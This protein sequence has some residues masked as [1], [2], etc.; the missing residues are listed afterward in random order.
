MEEYFVPSKCCAKGSSYQVYEFKKNNNKGKTNKAHPERENIEEIIMKKA[1]F[2]VYKFAQS[3]LT[4]AERQKSQFD[5]AIKLGAIPRKNKAI[6]YKILKEGRQAKRKAENDRVTLLEKN[7]KPKA[8]H[9]KKDPKSNLH[10][11]RKVGSGI[12]KTYGKVFGYLF[13]FLLLLINKNASLTVVHC[14][15]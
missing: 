6:N 11:K 14:S 12:L 10:K 7:I 8:K 4:N 9:K 13:Y 1:R 5:L 15:R 2:E 3:G